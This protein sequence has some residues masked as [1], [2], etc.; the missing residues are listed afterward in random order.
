M[1]LSHPFNAQGLS[2]GMPLGM[3]LNQEAWEAFAKATALTS[4]ETNHANL[5]GINALR[6]ENLDPVLRSVVAEYDHFAFFK[7]LSKKKAD[8]V[9]QEWMVQTSRGGQVQGRFNAEAGQITSNVGDYRRW[10]TEIKFLMDRAEVSHAAGIT[11]LHGLNA[12]ARENENA[13]V[14]LS[15]AANWASFYGNP[16]VAPRQFAGLTTQIAGWE[17]GKNVVD[18]QGTSDVNDFLIPQIFKMKAKVRQRGSF[19]N[20]TQ[21][22]VDD[23]TQNAIDAN[24]FDK[25]RVELNTNGVSYGGPVGSIK[26]SSGLVQLR[27]DIYIRNPDNSVHP[28]VIDGVLPDNAIAKPTIT[29]AATA[30]TVAGS[31]WDAARAGEYYYAVAAIN[32]NGVIGEASTITSGTVAAAGAIKITITKA[33][34]T[35]PTGYAIYRGAKDAATHTLEDLRLLTTVAD[36]GSATTVYDDKSTEVPGSSD[37]FAINGDPRAIDFVQFQAP[38]TF[39]LAAYDRAVYTWAVLLYGALRLALPHHHF[40]VKNFVPAGTDWKPF[41]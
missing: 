11:A 22:W 3:P 34:G 33:V 19:G 40:Y 15:E 13:L 24:L 29:V 2:A 30:P 10:F 36:S 26:T 17:G 37:I 8:T 41:G 35:A 38:T 9:L 12:R 6:Q 1:N 32:E 39:P 7:S 16:T 4:A 27:Q 20:I 28:I 25:Y 18:A 31:K 21:L 14:R 5:T 23:Y